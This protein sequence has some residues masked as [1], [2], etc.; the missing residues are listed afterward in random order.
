MNDERVVEEIVTEFILNT[1][2]LRPKFSQLA[3]EAALR[4][5]DCTGRHPPDEADLK[6]MS[7]H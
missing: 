2:R 1:C 3:V 6:L 5:V 7:L 4:S